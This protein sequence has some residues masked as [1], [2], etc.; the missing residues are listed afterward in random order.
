M[1][2]F[3]IFVRIFVLKG[4]CSALYISNWVYLGCLTE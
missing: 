1:Q 2:S 3:V 4:D